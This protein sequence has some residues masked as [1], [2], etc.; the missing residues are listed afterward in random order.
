M[1]GFCAS[2]FTCPVEPRAR[3]EMMCTA[4]GA[5]M[6][7][8]VATTTGKGKA[9]GFINIKWFSEPPEAIRPD[10]TRQAGGSRQLSLRCDDVH[11]VTCDAEWTAPSASHLV[12]KALDHGVRVHG[13]DPG[14]YTRE[15]ISAIGRAARRTRAD[16]PP[17]SR[18]DAHDTTGLQ[19]RDL[20]VDEAAAVLCVSPDTLRAW[21]QQFGYPQSAPGGAGE[22]RYA[23]AEVLALRDSLHAGL[24]IAAPIDK[25]R[26][27]GT[28]S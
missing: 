9:M 27:V 1:A 3:G 20:Q 14:W 24:S 19:Q 16:L 10:A 22:R 11:H 28:D 7:Q 26:R 4:G 12:A 8:A 17:D 6:V 13:F 2:K 18:S 21:E 23:Q 5:L 15:R 25:A